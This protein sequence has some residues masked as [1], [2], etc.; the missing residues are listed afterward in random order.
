MYFIASH[1]QSDWPT[2][3]CFLPAS[4]E[5]GPG[6]RKYK[7]GLFRSYVH[8]DSGKKE[9]KSYS[10]DALRK[11][12]QTS[13]ERPQ[14]FSGNA[15]NLAKVRLVVSHTE[16][17]RNMTQKGPFFGQPIKRPIS[18]S[19]PPIVKSGEACFWFRP[20]PEYFVGS[21]RI[22]FLYVVR[23][24]KDGFLHG[25]KVSHDKLPGVKTP[26]AADE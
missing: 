8:L 18:G 10:I 17:V 22:W 6:R 14:S 5:K 16:S 1:R 26:T 9:G 11:Y 3:K 21:G 2:E 25:R 7:K 23:A 12:C 19:L 20:L 15:E 13:E 4:E 24:G